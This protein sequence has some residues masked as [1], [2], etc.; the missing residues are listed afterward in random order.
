MALQASHL[1]HSP[2]CLR[3]PHGP[4]PF[5]S[6]LYLP[7]ATTYIPFLPA[8][9]SLFPSIDLPS[10]LSS[11]DLS[12]V[13]TFPLSFLSNIFSLLPS[14]LIYSPSFLSWTLSPPTLLPL[15]LL[16]QLFPSQTPFPFPY[17]HHHHHTTPPITLSIT[18]RSQVPEPN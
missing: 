14:F 10:F 4:P 8:L 5:S 16:P 15:P 2:T 9:L 18:T 6:A 17:H 1:Q 12:F 11:T 7:I 13:Y 3:S